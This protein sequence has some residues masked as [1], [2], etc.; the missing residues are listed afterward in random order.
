MRYIIFWDDV[1][2]FDVTDTATRYGMYLYLTF[3]AIKIRYWHESTGLK[4]NRPAT[5]SGIL[6]KVLE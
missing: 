6:F 4:I 5:T 2:N 3:G 1:F